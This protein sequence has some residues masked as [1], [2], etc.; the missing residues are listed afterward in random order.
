[1]KLSALP[2][3]LLKHELK[4]KH[5]HSSICGKVERHPSDT[6][7]YIRVVFGDGSKTAQARWT[8]FFNYDLIDNPFCVRRLKCL[9]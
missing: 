3:S 5:L 2:L 4:V 6:V 1:M 9:A 7:G 8:V